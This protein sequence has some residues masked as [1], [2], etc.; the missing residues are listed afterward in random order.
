MTIRIA[1]RTAFITGGANGIGL[2]I[3][4]AFAKAGAKVAL[5]D[6]DEE[7]L[8]TAELELS[9]LTSVAT[10][11]LDVCDREAFERSAVE[12]ESVLGPVSLLF[13]NAGL[14]GVVPV[15]KL[16]YELWDWGLG[17]NLN[18]V[19]NGVQTFLPRMLSRNLSGH[20]VQTASGAGLAPTNAGVL[21]STAK[22]AVVGMSEA[23]ARELTD[24]HIGVSVLCPGPVA[25]NITSHTRS[26]QPS[27]ME[28][29]ND[30]QI[31]A[32]RAES[33]RRTDFLAQG[34]APDAVGEHVLDAVR[35]NDLY[36]HTD[37]VMEGA[38]ITRTRQ[39]LET[40]PESGLRRANNSG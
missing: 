18:G 2:G 4:R 36:I 9:E 7:A 34:A 39:I 16:T 22:H 32:A 3:A 6:L 8:G 28:P 13:N 17:V 21:Y 10:V 19:I 27:V 37:R 5:A 23:L 11:V 38:I 31:S 14:A 40:M 12:V 30:E 1:G 25:T 24:F 35:R 15:S 29:K 26:M 33:A 20:I